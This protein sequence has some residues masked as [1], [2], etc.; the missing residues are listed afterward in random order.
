MLRKFLGLFLIVGLTLKIGMAQESI[1]YED[2]LRICLENNLG[3]KA[4]E[5]HIK[6]KKRELNAQR[7]LFLPQVSLLANYTMMSD[8]ITMD[9]NP[10]KE[11]ITP[12]YSALS[13]YGNF[14]DVQNPDPNTS[15][16]MPVFDDDISTMLARK[17]L[18]EG[19]E[20]IEKSDWTH[21]IQKKKF[22]ALNANV[23]FPIYAG[24]KIRA[25]NKVASI[26]HKEA[27]NEQDI[28]VSELSSTLVERYFGLVLAKEALKV[29]QEVFQT[30]EKHMSDAQKM[31][32]E[33][34]IPN[35]EFLHIKVYYSEAQ[36]ERKK[37]E[38]TI[39]IAEEGLQNILSAQGGMEFHPISNLFINDELPSLDLF[40]SE[41]KANSLLLKK[42]DFKKQLLKT[43]H[44]AELESYLPTITVAGTYRLAEK[45]LSETMPKYFVGVGVQW[46]ILHG[47]TRF[48]NIQASKLESERVNLTYQKVESDI[49]AVITKLYNEAKMYMEE[50]EDLKTAEEFADEYYRVRQK[51]F[52][53]G[54]S[55]ASEVSDANLAKAKVRIERLQAMYRYDSA[56]AKLL[57]YAGKSETFKDYQHNGH[58]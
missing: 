29:R 46:N 2:A 24:G 7:G 14:S 13:K 54:F 44:G 22:G 38:R 28:L 32:D 27:I 16:I 17:K 30:M 21:V 3:V 33:G 48:R 41:A 20:K 37:A 10:L 53:Q 35:A 11:S 6:A 50:F 4:G 51:A 40:L 45:D 19:L 42:V 23:L 47:A 31:K 9:M 57:Y 34:V 26:Y 5:S 58:Q 18:A 36:R 55:T 49:N 15:T 52:L 56:L 25:G 12:L 1:T 43:K 39:D 8:D